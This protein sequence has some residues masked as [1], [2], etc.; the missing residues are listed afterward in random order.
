VQF[1]GNPLLLSYYAFGIALVVLAVGWRCSTM[2]PSRAVSAT[3]TA[4]NLVKWWQ[5]ATTSVLQALVTTEHLQMRYAG[6]HPAAK[7]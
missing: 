7:S 4:K 5:R 1:A 3:S 2:T 6:E